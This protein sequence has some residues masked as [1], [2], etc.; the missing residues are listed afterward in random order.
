MDI[1]QQMKMWRKMLKAVKKGG[2]KIVFDSLNIND[3][4]IK[5]TFFEGYV[6]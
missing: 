1:S 4:N 5:D 3:H 2:Q 6:N